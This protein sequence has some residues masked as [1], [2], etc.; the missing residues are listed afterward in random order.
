[1]TA[2]QTDLQTVNLDPHVARGL[3]RILQ[4]S[5]I[6]VRRHSRAQNVIVSLHRWGRNLVLKIEDDGGGFAAFTGRIEGAAVEQDLRLPQSIKE[7]ARAIG[8]TLA[9]ESEPGAGARVEVQV[10]D[11][12]ETGRVAS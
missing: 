3:G 6:N 7:H 5:L 10:A 9:F 2:F 12:I 8:A 4:E 11:G 1:M